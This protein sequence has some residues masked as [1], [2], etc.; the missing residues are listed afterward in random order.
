MFNWVLWAYFAVAVV[1]FLRMLYLGAYLA[2][3]SGHQLNVGDHVPPMIVDAV[4]WGYFV[5]WYG[6]KSF[7]RDLGKPQ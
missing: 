5:V 3:Q 7:L 4:F 6:L 2:K 1:V